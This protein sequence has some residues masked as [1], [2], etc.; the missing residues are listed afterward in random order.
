MFTLR[1]ATSLWRRQCPRLR[2]WT[3]LLRATSLPANLRP[4]TSGRRS[5]Q[6]LVA[7][8]GTADKKTAGRS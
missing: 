8:V 4:I 7:F 5:S 3:N 1:H 6:A 2:A